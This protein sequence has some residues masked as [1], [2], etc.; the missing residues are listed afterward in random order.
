LKG[1]NSTLTKAVL[2]LALACIS[3]ASCG[4]RTDFRGQTS[5]SNNIRPEDR[6]LRLGQ[7]R[8]IHGTNIL[9]AEI[10]GA[11]SRG[12]L[13]SSSDSGSGNTRNLVF[14]SG[15]SL[16]SHRLFNTNEYVIFA[17]TE[18]PINDKVNGSPV[19]SDELVTKWLVYTVLKSDTNGDGRVDASDQR[20]IGVTDA[21]GSGYAEVLSGIDENFG[22]TM[23]NTGQVVVVYTRGGV[24]SATVIDL[25]NR[26]IVS[27]KALADLGSDVR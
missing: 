17:A 22:M 8:Q 10:T 18:Y 9:M 2:L 23:L 27:T 7:F 6:Q 19:R 21:S 11:L 13:S 12:S 3:L 14:V 15:E 26:K 16:D 25:E 5:N 4:K 24:K 20:T 1:T